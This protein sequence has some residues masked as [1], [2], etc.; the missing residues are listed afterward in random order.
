M[1]SVNQKKNIYIHRKKYN[2]G[3]NKI[4][5]KFNDVVLYLCSTVVFFIKTVPCSA[6]SQFIIFHIIFLCI[7]YVF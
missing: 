5:V 1:L 2:K 4:G 3:V 6:L 7:E